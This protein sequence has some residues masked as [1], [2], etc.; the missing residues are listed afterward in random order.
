MKT[1]N[2]IVCRIYSAIR[3]CMYWYNSLKIKTGHSSVF[4]ARKS[5]EST[6]N[7]LVICLV[8]LD[9]LPSLSFIGD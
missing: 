9:R 3:G 8:I 5:V 6:L 7:D 4:H 1:K 2:S